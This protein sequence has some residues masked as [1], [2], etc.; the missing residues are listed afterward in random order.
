MNLSPFRLEA[1]LIDSSRW[2]ELR[3]Q[4]P[5]Q[6][7]SII[8]SKDHGGPLGVGHNSEVG[9]FVLGCGQ[10]PHII[11]VENMEKENPG[12]PKHLR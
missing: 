1:D 10:G 7:L 9:W 11:R 5:S 4:M 8:D 2:P 12:K 6:V 3:D